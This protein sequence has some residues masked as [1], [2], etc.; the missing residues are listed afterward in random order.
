MASHVYSMLGM[1]KESVAANLAAVRVAAEFGERHSRG[2]AGGRAARLRRAGLREP[3]ARPGRGRARGA[4]R[5]AKATKIVGSPPAAQA[6][7]AAGAL[8][9]A[10]ERQDWKAAA[11]LEAR[12]A[13]RS[14][15][16]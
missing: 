15:R 4:E 5:A 9:Y 13:T 3:A 10:L 16:A 1:W 8:R 11:K 7:R 14:R 12:K 6:A 2:H